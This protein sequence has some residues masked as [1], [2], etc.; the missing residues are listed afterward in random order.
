MDPIFVTGH[1][2]TFQG[3][4]INV[5]VAGLRQSVRYLLAECVC[6]VSLPLP[7]LLLICARSATVLAKSNVPM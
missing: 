6:L 2:G 1:I 5:L 7:E 4:E 3:Q